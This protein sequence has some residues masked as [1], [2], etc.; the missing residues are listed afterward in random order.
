MAIGDKDKK[1]R[2]KKR[3]QQ[4]PQSHFVFHAVAPIATSPV[5]R[6]LSMAKADS[7]E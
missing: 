4:K 3:Q 5:P 6:K 1:T 7:Q 2:G